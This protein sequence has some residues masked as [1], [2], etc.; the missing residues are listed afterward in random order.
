MNP[1]TII[2]VSLSSLSIWSTSPLP[3]CIRRSILFAWKSCDRRAGVSV[4]LIKEAARGHPPSRA[5]E[6]NVLEKRAI[7]GSRSDV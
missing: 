4:F 1:E 7:H 2:T 3:V 5:S 6:S